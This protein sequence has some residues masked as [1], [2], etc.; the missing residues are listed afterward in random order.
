MTWLQ[1]EEDVVGT[2]A[3]FCYFEDSGTTSVRGTIA[4]EIG[5]LD[6]SRVVTAVTM[7]HATPITEQM[8]NEFSSQKT[9]VCH[10]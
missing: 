6:V 1:Q 7:V 4:R 10:T 5:L 8:Q 3:V 9:T 2:N